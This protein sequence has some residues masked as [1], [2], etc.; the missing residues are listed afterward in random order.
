[1]SRLGQLGHRLYTGEVSF[2]FVGRKRQWYAISGLILLI[3]VLAV[4]FRGLNFGIEFKGGAE[5]RVPNATCSIQY[6]RGA[7]SGIVQ[8]ESIVQK[9]NNNSLRVQTGDLTGDQPDAVTNALA[10]AC[11]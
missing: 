5:F 7:A 1:M 8:G 2:D 6:A 4:L 9:L 3:A 10:N 11:D